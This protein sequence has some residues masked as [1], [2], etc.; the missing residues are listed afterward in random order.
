MT[1]ENKRINMDIGINAGFG[2]FDMNEYEQHP[3]DSRI[4]VF[5]RRSDNCIEP[6]AAVTGG[7]F[8]DTAV[9]ADVVPKK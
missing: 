4:Y 9:S 2:A 6:G 3:A 5:V 1:T 8:A 7:C